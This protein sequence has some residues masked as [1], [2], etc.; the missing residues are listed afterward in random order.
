MTNDLF[1]S[2]EDFFSKMG[3]RFLIQ[4][5]NLSK[6]IAKVLCQRAL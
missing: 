5:A 3:M 6:E 4:L 2:D 1:L